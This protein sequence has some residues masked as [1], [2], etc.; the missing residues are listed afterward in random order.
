[1]ASTTLI[2]GVLLDLIT[3]GMLTYVGLRVWQLPDPGTGLHHSLWFWYG[4]SL[5]MLLDGGFAMVLLAYDVPL[6]VATAVLI[7]RRLAFSLGW[8]AFGA[9]LLSLNGSRALRAWW[10][11][12]AVLLGAI[13]IQAWLQGVGGYEV[14]TWGV[15]LLAADP[16]PLWLNV[17]FGVALFVPPGWQAVRLLMWFPRLSPVQRYR[18]AS[19]AGSTIVF[20]ILVIAGFIDNEWFWYGLLENRSV[21][22]VATGV[23]IAM[24]P[25]VLLRLRGVPRM[26]TAREFPGSHQAAD[27]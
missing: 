18:C 20:C 25:P 12:T 13:F 4:G 19:I 23:L 24:R 1:M 15:G 26:K 6:G 17:L 9:W 8:M 10:T 7:I 2:I 14:R 11:Y 21:F 3:A 22:T 16:T 27:V 5:F